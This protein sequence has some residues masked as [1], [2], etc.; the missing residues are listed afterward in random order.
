MTPPRGMR[1]ISFAGLVL[2]MALA[3]WLLGWWT[4]PLL[5]AVTGW[6]QRRAA[7]RAGLVGLAAALAW[8]LLLA[9][10]AVG[11]RFGAVSVELAG[12]M[13]LPLAVLWLATALLPA[14]LAWSAAALVARLARR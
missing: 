7:G 3:T 9:L 6:W 4:V 14:L 1:A 8:A 2:L 11:P 10:A 13:R 5:A 12:I